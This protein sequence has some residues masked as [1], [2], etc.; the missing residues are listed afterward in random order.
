MLRIPD[1]RATLVATWHQNDR[2]DYSLATRSSGRQYG[3]LDN[4]DRNENTFGG[5]SKF[6]IVD[7]KIN[8][9]L[10]RQFSVAVGV[11]NL[12]DEKIYVFHPY[13]QR[14]WILQAKGTF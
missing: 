5:V 1:W 9:K 2:L 12:T 11:E 14:T 4:S 8:V 3:E 6:L 7:A 10:D 13:P